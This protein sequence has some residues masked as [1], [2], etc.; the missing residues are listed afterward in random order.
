MGSAT[1]GSRMEWAAGAERRR[2]NWRRRVDG[3]R[4]IIAVNFSDHLSQCYVRLPFPDL[5]GHVVRLEDQMDATSYDRD[6]SELA[7]RG[8]YVDLP[9]WGC[10]VFKV[11]I[12]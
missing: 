4:L 8:L 6:G 1:S 9:A 7:S 11:R 2:K 12:S 3:Q 5:A 10:H